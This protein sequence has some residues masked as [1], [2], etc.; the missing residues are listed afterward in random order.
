MIVEPPRSLPLTV[1]MAAETKPTG[2]KPEFSQNVLSSTDVVASTSAGGI[3]S[4]V[5]TL[6]AVVAELR[7]ETLPVRS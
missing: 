2:S 3:W 7:E 6:A 1:S 4:N 5:T